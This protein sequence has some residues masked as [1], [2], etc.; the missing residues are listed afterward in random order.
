MNQRTPRG[1]AASG[2]V[3]TG[4]GCVWAPVQTHKLG[5]ANTEQRDRRTLVRRSARKNYQLC[6]ATVL[7]I[8]LCSDFIKSHRLS[9]ICPE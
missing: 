1:T 2:S 6:V 3:W 4:L 8:A 7:L 9:E 5:F